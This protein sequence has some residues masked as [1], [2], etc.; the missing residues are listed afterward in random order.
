MAMVDGDAE[1]PA[2]QPPSVAAP[3]PPPSDDPRDV[4][5]EELSTEELERRR[6]ALTEIMELMR[7][8]VQFDGGDLALVG[9]DYHAGVVEVELQGACGSCAISSMTLRAGVERMLKERLEWVREVRG[10]VDDSLDY[11]ESAAL[12]RGAYVPKYY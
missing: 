8:A 11:L 2:T 10:E 6:A 12:G 5:E 1:L 9:V 4:A 7:E 3:V